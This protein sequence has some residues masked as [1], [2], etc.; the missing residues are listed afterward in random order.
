MKIITEDKM[1]FDSGIFSKIETLWATVRF[2]NVHLYIIYKVLISVYLFVFPII[3][4]KPLDRFASN[5][6]WGTRESHENVLSLV[7]RF[8]VDWVDFNSVNLVSR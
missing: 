5:F 3:T 2:Y 6:D 8:E 4:Q 1:L 7:L